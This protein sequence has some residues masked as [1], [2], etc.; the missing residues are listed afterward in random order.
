MNL[1]LL[2]AVA[3]VLIIG[4]A[5]QKGPGISVGTLLDEMV[6]RDAM[7]RFPSIPYTQKQVSSYDRRTVSPDLPGWFANDD[8]A[9]IERLDTI[10]GRVEKVMFDEMG[11]GVITR[12]WMTTKDKNGVIRIYIDGGEKPDIVIPAY[13]MKRFPVAVPEGLSLTHTHYEDS[14]EGVGGNSFFLPIPYN[15]SCKVTFEEPDLTRKV[16][17]YYHINYRTYPEGTPVIS[18]SEKQVLKLKSKLVAVSDELLNPTR[19]NGGKVSSAEKLATLGDIVSLRIEGNNEAIYNLTVKVEGFGK[20]YAGVMENL[21][22]TASF[23]GIE[24]VKAPLSHFSGAGLGAQEVKSWNLDSDGKGTIKCRWIMPFQTKAEVSVANNS[25]RTV[26]LAVTATT[27]KYEWT[28]NSLYFHCTHHSQA[29]IPLNNDYYTNDNLDWNFATIKGRGIYVG[30]VLSLFNHAVDW[31]GEGD[32][33]IWIDD[34]RFPSHM[35]TGTEDYFNCS[36]APVVVFLTPYGGAPR[37]DEESSHGYN[38]FMR[39][40]NLDVIPFNS[41][42]KFDIEMLSWHIG[43]ADYYVTSFWYGDL[44]KYENTTINQ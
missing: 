43:T 37:A 34:D 35:G 1:K 17:R 20:D 3:A 19:Y 44:E 18:Y 26:N 29:G 9:G 23:D 12:I 6:S 21:I 25:E 13:D 41:M 14:M 22:L 16:P 2:P 7:T 11:P 33:K 36:W 42:F 32:E 15:K 27:D 39:T 28:D 5:S 30:D 10:A 38:T 24:T 8:G 4:C 40:R 31:Y